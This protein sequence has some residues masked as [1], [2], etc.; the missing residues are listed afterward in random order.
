MKRHDI[1][2]IIIFHK[3]E[4][5]QAFCEGIQ[6]SSAVDSFVTPEPS[7][8]PGYESKIIMAAGAFVS[9]SSIELSADGPLREPYAVFSQGGMTWQHAKFGYMM[10]VQNMINKKIFEL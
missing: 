10:T 5:L 6:H 7:R 8:T 3:P 1:I 9:G 2:Q 4:I